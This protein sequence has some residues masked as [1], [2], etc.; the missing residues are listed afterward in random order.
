MTNL[1]V[2]H[3]GNKS[4]VLPYIL[5]FIFGIG[6]GIADVRVGD[7]LV[8]A[9]LVMLATLVLGLLQPERAWRWMVVVGV[10]VPAT[11]LLAHF[12][13]KQRIDPSHVYL[14]FSSF[15][16]GTVGAYAGAFARMGIDLLVLPEK[17][18]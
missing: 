13:L 4:S 7:L 12:F 15:L 9:I 5:G 16:T 10:C 2:M 18:Q 3:N 6:A 17:K 1:K 11:Q 8:T 14:S